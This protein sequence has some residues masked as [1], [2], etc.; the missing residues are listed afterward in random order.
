MQVRAVGMSAA[1]VGSLGMQS[2][3][4]CLRDLEDGGEARVALGAERA[5]QAFPTETGVLGELRHALG[6]GD[7]TQGPGD[8]GRVVG[9]IFEPGV[10]VWAIA[11]GVSR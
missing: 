5:V 4:E 6:P 9:R 11:S 7:V 10:E 3:T 2:D 1:G 8:A